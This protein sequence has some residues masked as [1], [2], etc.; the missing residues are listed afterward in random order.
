MAFTGQERFRGDVS[1][2]HMHRSIWK[3]NSVEK[4]H[5]KPYHH[6]TNGMLERMKRAIKE[7]EYEGLEQLREHV[8]E[9]NFGKHLKALR[10]KHHFERCARHRKRAKPLIVHRHHLTVVLNRRSRPS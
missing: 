8:Q 6:W 7:Y 2:R 1:Y 10:W 9:F 5:S 4:R 3:F